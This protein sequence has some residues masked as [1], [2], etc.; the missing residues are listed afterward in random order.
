M[1][2][3]MRLV[4]T[5]PYLPKQKK[6]VNKSIYDHTGPFKMHK[7]AVIVKQWVEKESLASI[8]TTHTH[9]EADTHILLLQLW[10]QGRGGSDAQIASKLPAQSP[11]DLLQGCT[12][13]GMLRW[14]H[15]SELLSAAAGK[16]A[17]RRP[18][19]RF[20]SGI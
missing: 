8:S 1:C 3:L 12:G 15:G 10:L 14:L 2:Q 17:Q 4:V 9:A 20:S 16:A 13:M 5:L 11:S 7:E 6:L 18:C 19:K